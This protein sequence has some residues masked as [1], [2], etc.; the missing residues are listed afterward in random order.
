MTVLSKKRP[1]RNGIGLLCAGIAL[2][3]V[4]L[5]GCESPHITNTPRTAVEQLLLSSVI[6]QGT[7]QM[8]FCTYKGR[9]AV[10]DY[11]YLDPQAD[12]P[13]VQGLVERRLAECGVTVVADA[14]D[15]DII[16]QVLCPVLATD[17]SKIFIGLP[18]FPFTYERLYGLSIIIP[19]I[20]I[21][22]KLT[23][24]GYGRFSLNI[25]RASDL[26]PLEIQKGINTRSE[27]INW[28]LLLI[29]WSN[30]N[31]GFRESAP[32]TNCTYEFSLF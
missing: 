4:L 1:F 7:D 13:V 18:R 21:F 6:E 9:K 17:M 20:P 30:D 31:V 11:K 3:G 24:V 25:L 10:M 15:A 2:A 5:C 19:E 28:T 23:R 26:I 32:K 14:K 12:K 16:V 22:E 29:E 27:Y 8:D